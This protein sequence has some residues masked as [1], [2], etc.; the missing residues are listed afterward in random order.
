MPDMRTYNPTP[1]DYALFSVT[2]KQ[3][4]NKNFLGKV[5]RFKTQPAGSGL[6]PGKY[7][8]LQ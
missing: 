1:V 3:K 8:L 2:D 7:A 4:H 6:G 5:Q